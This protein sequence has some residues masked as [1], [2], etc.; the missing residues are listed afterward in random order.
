ME[1]NADE[2]KKFIEKLDPK[3][4]LKK[5]LWGQIFLKIEAFLVKYICN[6]INALIR[7]S[8]FHNEWKEADIVPIHKKDVFK[9]AFRKKITNL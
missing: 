8:K 6:G 3:R 9:R 4:L 1:T 5:L 7:S 2:F